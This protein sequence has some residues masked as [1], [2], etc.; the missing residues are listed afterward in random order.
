MTLLT[1]S[2]HCSRCPECLAR[3]VATVVVLIDNIRIGRELMQNVG[4]LTGGIVAVRGLRAVREGHGRATGEAIVGPVG[5]R[6]FLAPRG[7]QFGQRPGSIGEGDLIELTSER[8][9]TAAAGTDP[10]AARRQAS[11]SL[12]G[13][14]GPCQSEWED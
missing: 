1:F 12:D 8:T 9:G 2:R 11:H 6:L 4:H 10:E 5:D 13:R 7:L 3:E 14:G